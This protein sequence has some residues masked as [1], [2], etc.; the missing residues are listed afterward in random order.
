MSLD[1]VARIKNARTTQLGITGLETAI[2]LIAFVVVASVFA[3]TVL[4]TG[5]FSSERGKETIFAGLR[6]VQSSITPSGSVIA[7]SGDLGG[8]NAIFK[9]SFV[10][11]QTPG[12]DAIDLTPPFTSDGSAVDPD[13]SVTTNR[14]TIQYSDLN[15]VLQDVPWTM[16]I[17]G[18]GTDNILDIGEKAEITVWLLN[19][20]T[21]TAIDATDSIAYMTSGGFTS[22]NTLLDQNDTFT[23]QLQPTDGSVMILERTLPA[24]LHSVNNL[25]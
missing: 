23:L 12:A 13:S 18:T 24:S 19:R 25:K 17:I 16:K 15:Q 3:F 22:S 1:G 2:I 14:V 8:A 20:N 5:I 6:Q 10:V 7:F 21:G 9:I 4:G 11:Q